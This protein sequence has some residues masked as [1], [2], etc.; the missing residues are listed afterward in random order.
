MNYPQNG[1]YQWL[2]LNENTYVSWIFMA[3]SFWP[4]GKAQEESAS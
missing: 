4:C 1:F 3:F 2:K